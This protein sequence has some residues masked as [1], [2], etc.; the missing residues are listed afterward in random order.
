MRQ[1]AKRG[2]KLILL[3]VKETANITGQTVQYIRKKAQT[4]KIRATKTTN[5]RNRP[6]YMIPITELTPEQQIAYYKSHDLDIPCDLIPHKQRCS[7]LHKDFEQLTAGQKKQ[8]DLWVG[9]LND[10]QEFVFAYG[11]TKLDANIEFVAESQGRYP[12]KI[13]LD[14]LYRKRRIYKSG[15]LADLADGRGSGRKGLSCI[16]NNIWQCFLYYYL[17]QVQHPITACYNYTEQWA[18]QKCPEL[19]PLPDISTF[20]R[21]VKSEIPIPVQILGR[22]GEK[23]YR[24]RCG[25]YI[26]RSYEQMASNE[27]WIADNHT[28]DV[29][30]KGS[31][32]K[33]KRVYLTAFI[34][35]R[36]GIFTGAYV[37]Q[38][39]SSQA[40]ITALR[41]GILKYGIPDN[42]YVDNGREFL[43]GDVGGL[44]HRQKKST[45]DKF[46]PPPIFE[47][48]GI[49]MTNALVRNAKAKLIE[50]R[51]LDV[52]NQVSRL[53]DSFTGGNV[54]EKPEQLKMILKNG[55]YIDEAAFTRQIEDILTYYLNEQPYGGSVLADKGKTCAQVYADRLH[56]KRV[57]SA[58][59]LHLML[60]R[61]SK[62]QKVNRRGVQLTVCGRKLDYYND[63]LLL[64]WFGKQVYY[65]YDP[66]DISCVRVYDLKD[67]YITTAPCDDVT[68]SEYGASK[69]KVTEAMREVRRHEK[70]AKESLK[71]NKIVALGAIN[72]LDIVL[73]EVEENKAKEQEI[74]AKLL[75]IQRADEKQVKQLAVGSDVVIDKSK[76]IK[77]AKKRNRKDE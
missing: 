73:Q 47:R 58:E 54:L 48:L 39:P 53:F 40:T 36:S 28:F 35:A 2:I 16:D 31:N 68:I 44:G 5:D 38:S 46:I 67:R 3:T 49:N 56:T 23:A 6:Q 17:D 57:A 50:R 45:K 7:V 37:T 63:E 69:E 27:W 29:M 66:E 42:I 32:G 62:A 70:I 55:E 60:M 13:S 64:N 76:M 21:H 72:A 34:D 61:S 1:T 15:N 18:K 14:I 52:K 25:L 65:R 71:S 77:N 11:G 74:N 59:D 22:E 19:L 33:P 10:W 20:Y 43:T 30:V 24:D 75:T 41:K 4:G 12:V 8:V 51:F 9:I 26:R